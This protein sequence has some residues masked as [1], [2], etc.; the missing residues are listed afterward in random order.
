M[1]EGAIPRIPENIVDDLYRRGTEP[2]AGRLAQYRWITPNRISLAGFLVG[3][4]GASICILT[5]PLWTAGILFSL[6]DILD[7]LDGDLARRQGTSSREGAIF[8]ATLDRYTDF[9]VIGALT[10]LTAVKLDRFPDL[11]IGHLS[12][13][14]SEAALALGLA[15]LLGT[16]LTPYV[17]AKTE[18]EGKSSVATIGDRGVRNHILVVGLLASQPI[19]A[20]AALAVVT[21]LAAIRRLAHALRRE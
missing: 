13:L 17:R 11:L 15:A 18:A 21:N 4:V 16:M 5:L 14:T 3:G 20:L 8:D 12:F 1:Q 9:L 10:Y 2:L 6:G 19:W 7:Y